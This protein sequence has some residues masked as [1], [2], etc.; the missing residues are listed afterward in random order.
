MSLLLDTHAAIWYLRQSREISRT[1]LK[2][3]RE[4]VSKGKPLYVSAISL[5][6]AIYL[7][8]RGRIPLSA[9]MKLEGALKDPD[10]GLK[11]APVDAEV[12]EAIYRIP[13]QNV[14][15]MP[16]RIICATALCRNLLLITKDARIQ[17]IGIKTIW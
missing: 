8:E 15:D 3:I 2:T 16:D 6:E 5:V 12:A 11:V 13:R 7:V 9:I 4:A 17:T 1:A 10:S 14:P